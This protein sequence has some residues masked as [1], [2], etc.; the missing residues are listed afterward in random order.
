MQIE[1]IHRS[2]YCPVFDHLQYSKAKGGGPGVLYYINH[3]SVHLDRQ[4]R[5]GEGGGAPK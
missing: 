1:H 2:S 4:R 3:V 5:G